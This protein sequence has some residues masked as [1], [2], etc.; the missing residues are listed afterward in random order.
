MNLHPVCIIYCQDATLMQRLRSFLGSMTRVQQANRPSSLLMACRQFDPAILLLDLCAEDSRELLPQVIREHP[1]L[2]AIAIA[3]KNI[4]TTTEIEN[5]GVWAIVEPDTSRQTLQGLVQRAITHLSVIEENRILR[6]AREPRSERMT[7]PR[8]EES[9]GGPS[10]L[11]HFSRAF[12]HF[13]KLETMLE[14]LMEGVAGCARVSRAG[15]FVAENDG[16]V[17]RLKAGLKCLEGTDQIEFSD[18][19]SLLCWMR[20][21]PQLISRSVLSLLDNPSEALFLKQML[22]TLG[23][24]VIVPLH[25]GGRVAGWIFFGRHVTGYPFD[26]ADFE[27]LVGLAEH[28]SVIL[29]NG[30]LYE[31]IRMQKTLA[32]TLLHSMPSGIVAVNNA[33]KIHWFNEE[34]ERILEKSSA[35]VMKKAVGVIGSRMGDLVIQCLRGKQTEKIE[36]TDPH[37]KLTLR[38]QTRRLV[39]GDTCMGAVLILH[40]TTEDQR[41]RE[42]QDR[43]DR[44]AFWTELAAA[45]SHE[46]R[47]PLV[48]ISTF[49][50]L[51]PERYD[52]PEFREKF[53][54]LAQK[55]IGRVNH[56]LNQLDSFANQPDLKFKPVNIDELLRKALEL[57]RARVPFNGTDVRLQADPSLPAIQADEAS[58][59]DCFAHLITNSVEAMEGMSGSVVTVS[60]KATGGDNGNRT[61][62]ISVEDK[63]KGIPLDI[64]DKIF[65]PFCS[66]KAHGIGLGLPIVKRTVTDH[67]GKVSIETSDKGT[68]VAV[69]LPVSYKLEELQLQGVV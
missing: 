48:A 25:A 47:N 63:G 54:G 69:E 17:Y 51:L 30:V 26:E 35:D 53:S 16:A 41:L 14:H 1:N 31:E 36:W 21:N 7:A 24:E 10:S 52:D 13:D 62:R 59:M 66:V 40:D 6:T 32:E 60:A 19:D 65:S 37:T 4:E 45:I 38:I 29:E 18:D 12:R 2:I 15:V 64:S 58:L 33:G 27:E 22:D 67:N 3:P 39:D 56:L 50:Q 5:D 34:A 55:E 46:V 8:R 44:A 61:I 42:R 23:A 20:M 43:M 68:T 49:A 9:T 11:F 57:A 28:V